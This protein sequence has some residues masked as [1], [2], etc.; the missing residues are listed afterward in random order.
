MPSALIEVGFITNPQEHRRLSTARY[1]N[2]LAE[3]LAR[4]I[5]AY[6]NELKTAQSARHL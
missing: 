5:A 4:G 2:E 3:G 6:A 1:R